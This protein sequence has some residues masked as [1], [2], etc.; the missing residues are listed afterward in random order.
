M[1]RPEFEGNICFDGGA[2]LGE[3]SVGEDPVPLR[4]G[5]PRRRAQRPHEGVPLHP[6]PHAN[7]YIFLLRTSTPPLARVLPMCTLYARTREL[8]HTLTNA[9]THMHTQISARACTHAQACTGAYSQALTF[10]LARPP[11]RPPARPHAHDTNEQNDCVQ[12]VRVRSHLFAYVRDPAHARKQARAIAQV[13]KRARRLSC[14]SCACG[15][16]ARPCCL[17]RPSHPSGAPLPPPTSFMLLPW[18][19]QTSSTGLNTR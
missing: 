7:S 12:Y 19:D 9:R 3:D 5:S 11:A 14:P 2:C 15:I 8:A 4:H 1:F 16:P 6:G 13:R 18:R 17:H 10:T